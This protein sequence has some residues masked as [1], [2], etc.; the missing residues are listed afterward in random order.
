VPGEGQPLSFLVEIDDEDADPVRFGYPID[1]SVELI[2]LREWWEQ[3]GRPTKLWV[4]VAEE[5]D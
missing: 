1:D 4:T 2:L 3:M 5:S